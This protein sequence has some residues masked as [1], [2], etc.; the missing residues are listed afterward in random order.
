MCC[1]F[2]WATLDG[3]HEGMV[4]HQWKGL[5]RWATSDGIYIAAINMLLFPFGDLQIE[6]T[7]EIGQPGWNQDWQPELLLWMKW[8]SA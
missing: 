1:C 4:H 7:K 3:A 6:S 2:N 8:E 5:K